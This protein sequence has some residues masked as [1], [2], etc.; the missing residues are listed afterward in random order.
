[1]MAI[2][3]A[4]I[5]VQAGARVGELFGLSKTG[6]SGPTFVA[7]LLAIAAYDLIAERRVHPAT[8]WGGIVSIGSVA[9]VV[10][11]G[12][13]AFGDAIVELLRSW[14]VGA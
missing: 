1:M 10:I 3:A 12:N 6:L 7:L 2:A 4:N 9:A 13:S 11:L 8:I 5:A 14:R